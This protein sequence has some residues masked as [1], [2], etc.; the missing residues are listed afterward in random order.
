MALVER[1]LFAIDQKYSRLFVQVS[2]IVSP[3]AY[4]L[5]DYQLVAASD[6]LR[7]AQACVWMAKL[8]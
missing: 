2:L 8:A 1:F 3:L 6:V 4:V 7:Y 5:A